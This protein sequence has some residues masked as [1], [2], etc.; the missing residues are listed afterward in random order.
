ML[1]PAEFGKAMAAIV[2]EATAPLLR[3]IEELEAREAPTASDVV[4]LVLG[5]DEIKCLVNLEA[6]AYLSENPPERGEKGQDGAGIADLLI[7]R[8]GNLVATMTDGRM[9]N[10]GPVVGKDGKPGENGKDGADFSDVE[11]D[12]DGERTIRIKGRGGEIVK[13]IPLPLDKGYWSEGQYEKGDIVT[14]DGI[15]WIALRDT[16]AAPT[17][18]NKQDWRILARK[19]RDGRDGRNGVDRTKAVEITAR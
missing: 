9:K 14:H 10:L 3:R 5:S 19:G 4:R 15:A 17:V 8:E 13:R 7:D 2:K 18:A 11:I 6:E 12:Y 1:D 16:K